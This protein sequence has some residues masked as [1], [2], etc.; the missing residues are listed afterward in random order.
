MA[1]AWLIALFLGEP[2]K[3]QIETAMVAVSS[4]MW[5]IVAA[6]LGR[7]WWAGRK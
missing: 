1:V 5:L 6:H 4:V 3:S 2:V 7:Q